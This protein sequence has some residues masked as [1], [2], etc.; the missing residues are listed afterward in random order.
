MSRSK[1]I[2]IHQEMKGRCQHKIGSRRCRRK[3]A[4]DF[5]Y[6]HSTVSS[7]C[8]VCLD[9]CEWQPF[10]RYHAQSTTKL[11]CRHMFHTKCIKSWLRK[12]STC[13]LCRTDCPGT[14][15]MRARKRT[16][17]PFQPL[18]DLQHLPPRELV[19]P[20]RA[21]QNAMDRLRILQNADRV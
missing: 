1:N 15:S 18:G 16:N 3:C 5:C 21:A 8:P 14:L 13:P 12:Q 17:S 2:Q 9:I 10:A 4:G 7:V 11:P 6:A 19:P 20:R